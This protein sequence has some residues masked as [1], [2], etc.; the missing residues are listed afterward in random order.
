MSE[1][2]RNDANDLAKRVAEKFGYEEKNSNMYHTEEINN[3]IIRL[4]SEIA[5]EAI[6]EYHKKT[7]PQK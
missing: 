4:A 5:T 1:F 2:T 6:L 3:K 7:S